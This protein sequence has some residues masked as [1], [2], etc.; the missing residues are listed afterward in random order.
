MTVY[1]AIA[2]GGSLGALCRFWV[3]SSTYAALGT[4]FP[5]GT[6]LVNVSG[7]LLMGFLVVLLTEKLLLPEAIKMALLVGFLGAFTTFS[8]FAL[9]ALHWMQQGEWMKALVYVM[10]SVFGSLLGVAAGFFGARLLLK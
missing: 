8:T 3:A 10:S 9:D 6:L 5:Y 7:S 2:L 4:Q 1:I